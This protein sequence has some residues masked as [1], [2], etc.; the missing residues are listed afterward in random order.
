MIRLANILTWKGDGYDYVLDCK[1]A[2]NL[3]PEAI[4][5]KNDRYVVRHGK[6]WAIRQGGVGTLE[7]VHRAQGG[8]QQ[9]ANRTI[10]GL[11]G[12]E[13]RIQ[14]RDGKWRDS[15]T[16]T[17]GND[18]FPRAT[19]CGDERPVAVKDF[20][21][22]AWSGTVL[23][24]RATGSNCPISPQPVRQGLSPF[25]ESRGSAPPVPYR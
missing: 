5:A 15:D 18:P 25:A 6:E 3:N 2:V 14:R 10:C 13:V 20:R 4:M 11:G 23:A 7:S 24:E 21:S 8:A 19:V 1:V 17:R 16:V 9:A 22:P 12:G